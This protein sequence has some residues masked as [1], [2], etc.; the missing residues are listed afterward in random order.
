M[1]GRLLDFGLL[2]LRVVFG[3]GLIYHGWGKIGHI[4]SFTQTVHN[5]GFP[6]AA[7]FAWASVFAEMVGGFFCLLGLWTRWA[8]L[9]VTINM[10]VAAFVRHAPDT[11]DVMEKAL[12]YLVVALALIMTGPGRISVDASRGHRGERKK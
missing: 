9:V 5:I 8:A 1:N 4:E 2:L 10:A 3:L 7:L 11:F 6:A 12:A